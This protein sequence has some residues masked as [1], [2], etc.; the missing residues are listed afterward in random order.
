VLAALVERAADQHMQFAD[1]PNAPDDDDE[2]NPPGPNGGGNA[3]GVNG[4]DNKEPA[5]KAEAGTEPADERGA[6]GEHDPKDSP[7]EDTEPAAA[8]T[9][10]TV[11]TGIPIAP[12]EPAPRT[13]KGRRK[14]SPPLHKPLHKRTI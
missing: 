9:E 1:D 3:R 8:T 7:A 5:R 11:T 2:P 13:R 6:A 4:A 12:T 10:P 14:K